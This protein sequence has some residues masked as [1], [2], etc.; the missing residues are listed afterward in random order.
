MTPIIAPNRPRST[1]VGPEAELVGVFLAGD[2]IRARAG[3]RV[4]Y[5]REPKL[6]SGCPDIV[7]TIWDPSVIEAWRGHQPR[8]SRPELRI[9]EFLNRVRQIDLADLLAILPFATRSMV[10]RLEG[11]GFAALLIGDHLRWSD[12]TVTAS[13]LAAVEDRPVSLT[14]FRMAPSQGPWGA[15]VHRSR[16]PTAACRRAPPPSHYRRSR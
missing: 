10:Q 13:G 5:F 1:R 12:T 2:P 16:L 7:A 6:D 15:S 8:L 4:T 14:T 9:A 11:S 3:L